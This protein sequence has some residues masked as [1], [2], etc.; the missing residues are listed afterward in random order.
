MGTHVRINVQRY[1]TTALSQERMASCPAD[2][3][4]ASVGMS[5]DDLPG[6]A[7]PETFR[8]LVTA[9]HSMCAG[10]SSRC[11]HM[12][13]RSYVWACEGG[14]HRPPDLPHGVRVRRRGARRPVHCSSCCAAVVPAAWFN[15][16][17]CVA[18]LHLAWRACTWRASMP[19]PTHRGEPCTRNFAPGQTRPAV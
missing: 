2:P 19:L 5:N 11:T 15:T 1:W 4:A 6:L 9:K 10:C 3:P 17:T 12:Y 13:S 16:T 8:A 14:R 7:R 18:C